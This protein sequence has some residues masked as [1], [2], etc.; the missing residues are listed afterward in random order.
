[1]SFPQERQDRLDPILQSLQSLE[2]TRTVWQDDFDSTAINV[3]VQLERTRNHATH[4]D[5]PFGFVVGLRKMKKAIADA[6]GVAASMVFL[7]WPSPEYTVGSIHGK[8]YREKDGYSSD[9]IKI[10]IFV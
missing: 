2:G 6:I 5:K 8:R 7:D 1:M 9:L 10:E 4:P 3:F